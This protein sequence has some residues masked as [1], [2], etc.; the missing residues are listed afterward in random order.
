MISAS[1]SLLNGHK[2]KSALM[3]SIKGL[4]LC[5][6]TVA[7]QVEQISDNLE[8]QIHQDLQS[9]EYFSLQLDESTDISDVAQLCVVVRIV[10]GDFTV[11]EEFVKLPPLHERAR[12]EDI[13]NVFLKFVK[14]CN[15]L[16]SKLV[17]ITTDG[18]PS[19]TGR[20]NGFLALCA[21]D[22]SFP[23]V[24][25]YHCIKYQFYLTDS[26]LDDALRAACSSYTPDFRQLAANMQC[27]IS[28]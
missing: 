12:G 18:A 7:R 21:K 6:K 15:L 19:I 24:L 14:E 8:S 22:E 17:A 1:E 9:C 27:Q 25:S 3:T 4:Q 13:M 16:L 2:D 10:F 26:H 23:S 5:H 11:R 20:N 28:H